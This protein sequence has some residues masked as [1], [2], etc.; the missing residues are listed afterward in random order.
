MPTSQVLGFSRSGY[1]SSSLS[2]Y[3]MVWLLIKR[4]LLE[5]VCTEFILCLSAMSLHK[6]GRATHSHTHPLLT[7]QSGYC[8]SYCLLVGQACSNNRQV[9]GITNTHIERDLVYV[10]PVLHILYTAL[11]V[12]MN[13][14]ESIYSRIF[15]KQENVANVI[16]HYFNKRG[17]TNRQQDLLSSQLVF[18]AVRSNTAIYI[19]IYIRDTPPHHPDIKREREREKCI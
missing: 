9:L 4:C 17:F 6:V 2:L 5:C 13:I 14:S 15:L 8:K 11:D 12:V 3:Y 10:N 18:R 16:I 7:Q 19:Y 1:V